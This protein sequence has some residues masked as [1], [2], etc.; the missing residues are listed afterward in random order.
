[1]RRWLILMTTHLVM[2][3]VGFAGGIYTLPILTAPQAPAT[4]AALG[5]GR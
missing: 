3:G 1:M 2:L 4:A 5:A